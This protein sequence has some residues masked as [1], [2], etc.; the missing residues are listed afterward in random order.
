MKKLVLLAVCV[1]ISGCQ[2]APA[3]KTAHQSIT[4]CQVPI[5]PAMEIC[6]TE[7]GVFVP[8]ETARVMVEYIKALEKAVDCR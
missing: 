6:P 3:E 7:G 8:N 4:R 1:I 2:I 5:R